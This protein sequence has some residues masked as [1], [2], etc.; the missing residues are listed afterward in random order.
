MR[1]QRWKL[2]KIEKWELWQLKAQEG[3]QKSK[4]EGKQKEIVAGPSKPLPA[5]NNK[6][7]ATSSKK[8]DR[9]GRH[10]YQDQSSGH[11]NTR[12][13]IKMPFFAMTRRQRLGN[14]MVNLLESEQR[15]TNLAKDQADRLLERVTKLQNQYG[16]KI[17]E[18]EELERQKQKEAQAALER[19]QKLQQILIELLAEL[20]DLRR[21]IAGKAKLEGEFS[22][23][24]AA[25][26]ALH[27]S[28]HSKMEKY[29][30]LQQQKM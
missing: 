9:F 20:A 6:G 1:Q 15:S 17:P 23:L 14:Q 19:E 10:Q 28:M 29:N 21:Q 18:E 11:F 3:I 26:E 13:L 27:A 30:N 8:K 24:Q 7:G 25:N 5:S 2:V 22:T 12:S 16:I 4:E